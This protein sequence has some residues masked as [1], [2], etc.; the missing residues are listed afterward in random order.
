MADSVGQGIGLGERFKY[1]TTSGTDLL[2]KA[3]QGKIAADKKAEDDFVTNLDFK[4]DY[5]KTLPAYGKE[6]TKVASGLINK[7]QQYKKEDPR[8]A[9]N[10]VE[11]D[12]YQ[13]RMELGSG[14]P[15]S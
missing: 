8:T 10:R 2:N 11:A 7:Y 3:V 9:R 1:D 15:F 6:M 14:R 13:A 12:A 5:S 4:V